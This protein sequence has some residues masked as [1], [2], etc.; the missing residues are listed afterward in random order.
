VVYFNA[1]AIGGTSSYAQ[2]L[3][4]AGTAAPSLPG[5]TIAPSLPLNALDAAGTVLA[6]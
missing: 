6:L 3:C 4:Y 1:D 5:G 2:P